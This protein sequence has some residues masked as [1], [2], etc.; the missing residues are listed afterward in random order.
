MYTRE[1]FAQ[2]EHDVRTGKRA[3]PTPC[4]LFGDHCPFCGNDWKQEHRE[5]CESPWNVTLLFDAEREQWEEVSPGTVTYFPGRYLDHDPRLMTGEAIAAAPRHPQLMSPADPEELIASNLWW[6]PT[7]FSNRTD[8]L[9][10]LLLGTGRGYKWGEDGNL[11]SV[12]AHIEPDYFRLERHFEKREAE[13]RKYEKY[14]DDQ[15]FFDLLQEQARERRAELDAQLATRAEYLTRARE[16]G[17][18]RAREYIGLPQERQRSFRRAFERQYTLLFT[19]PTNVTPAWRAVL[20][21][22]RAVFAELGTQDV[23][24]T[25]PVR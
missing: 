12:F 13:A 22:A 2:L 4:G 10:H 8:V 14:K 17:P 25:R 15:G 24:P 23:A 1:N 20:D 7:L 6:W 19:A 5:D 16:Y 18:V 9:D 11:H 21:E 3:D